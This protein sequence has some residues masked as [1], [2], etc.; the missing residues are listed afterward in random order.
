MSILDRILEDKRE[1]LA[2]Q[3]MSVSLSAVKNRA[4][5]QEPV[6]SLRAALRG[7]DISVIAE[8]KRRSPSAGTINENA[9]PAETA[10]AYQNAGAAALS[11]LTER[12]YFG[13]RPNDLVRARAATRL[14][15]LRKDF[16]FDAY[17]VYESRALGADAVLL[18]ARILGRDRLSR[19]LAE[20]DKTG[21]EALVEVHS[22]AELDDALVAGARMVGVNNR[23]LGTFETDLGVVERLAP[24]VP[25]GVQVVSESGCRTAEDVARLRAVGVDAALIGGAL[26]ESDDINAKMRELLG[27]E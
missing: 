3:I 11:V 13:G 24:L 8:F 9:D 21:I 12:R 26:M 25:E 23:D 14:P 6:R 16:I 20:I 27:R 2:E 18:I 4:D 22:E 10:R 17:Q 19:M 5:H 1:E 7:S 15:V